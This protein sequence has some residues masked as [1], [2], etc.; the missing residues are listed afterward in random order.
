[1]PYSFI[2][3][4]ENIAIQKTLKR[5]RQNFFKKIKLVKKKQIQFFEIK[6]IKLAKK[7]PKKQK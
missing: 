6:K 1:M 2:N 3:F 7:W 4:T 5:Q